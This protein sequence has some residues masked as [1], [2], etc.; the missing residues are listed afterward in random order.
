MREQ[1]FKEYENSYVWL[2]R[3]EIEVIGMKE[4][5]GVQIANVK[6][7][8]DLSNS[9]EVVESVTEMTCNYVKKHFNIDAN[10]LT[11]AIKLSMESWQREDIP[12]FQSLLKLDEIADNRKLFNRISAKIFDLQQQMKESR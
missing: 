8:L 10:S 7:L 1:L 4:I 11:D 5:R 9:S 2:R 3:E 6:K 12:F